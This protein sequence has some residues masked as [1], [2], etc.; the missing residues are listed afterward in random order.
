ME[1]YINTHADDQSNEEEIDVIA[2][3]TKILDKGEMKQILEVI[4]S[5]A[6]SLGYSANDRF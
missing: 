4:R 1:E 2:D 5:S 6:V 3:Y